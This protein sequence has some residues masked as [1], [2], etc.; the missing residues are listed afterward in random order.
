VTRRLRQYRTVFAAALTLLVTV[1]CHSPTKEVAESPPAGWPASLNDFT[2]TWTGEPGIDLTADAAVVVR[3]YMESYYLAYLTTDRKYLYPGFQQSVAANEPDGPAGSQERWPVPNRERTWVGTARHHLLRIDRSDR[4][5]TVVGC[6]YSYGTA[7]YTD[8]GFQA[9]VGGT[10]PN[11]GISAF[12]VEMRAPAS[13]V[14][15]PPQQG[16]SRA[17]FVNV[18]DGWQV[19]NY[20][21]GFLLLAHWDSSADEVLCASRADRTP[22]SRTFTPGNSYPR[23]DFPTLPA[24]PG[25][26]AESAT[27]TN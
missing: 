7:E 3:A 14:N 15:L 2:I 5:V 18:F 24:A 19:S 17:P 4:D 26:P 27:A 23:S 22:E 1:G 10:G 20:Q 16:D 11:S 13:A 21:G 9:N 12:R 25:W 8:Y 6:V